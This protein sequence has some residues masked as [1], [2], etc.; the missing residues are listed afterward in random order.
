MHILPAEAGILRLKS[1]DPGQKH[2]GMT[3]QKLAGIT[4][5]QDSN[6]TQLLSLFTQH[7]GMYLVSI[8]Y[9][10]SNHYIIIVYNEIYVAI[11][12]KIEALLA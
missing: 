11:P 10:T 6:G 5:K 2:A 8:D 7:F 12:S 1:L 3:G 9:N 4:T